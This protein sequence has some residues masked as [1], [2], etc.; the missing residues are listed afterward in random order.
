[1]KILLATSNK[2]KVKELKQLLKGYEIFGLSEVLT[3][4]EIVEDGSTFAQNATIKARA[5]Y[6]KLIESNLTDFIALSDDSGISVD[7][8]DGAPGIYS[9]RYHDGTELGNR[10]KL[11]NELIL[12]NQKQSKAHYTACIAVASKFGE[13]CSH[14]FMNGTV[15]TE[16]KGQNGFGYD[17]IFIPNGFNQTLGQLDDGT[18]EKISHRSKAICNIIPVLRMLNKKY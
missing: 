6:K 3:P 10:L 5:V 11:I 4:F 8:L 12:K 18:K 2:G 7:L 9:A 15:I 14:G 13:Y 16:Q 17:P 1:M